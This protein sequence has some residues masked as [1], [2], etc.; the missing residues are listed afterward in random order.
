M[1]NKSSFRFFCSSFLFQQAECNGIASLHLALFHFLSFILAI[2]FP[3]DL[4][5]YESELYV[6]ENSPNNNN[7]MKVE[8]C[9]QLCDV[10][11][12]DVLNLVHIHAALA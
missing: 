10:S 5:C 6:I 12:I 9:T 11:E 7:N 3:M 4:S 1:K 8:W 2:E